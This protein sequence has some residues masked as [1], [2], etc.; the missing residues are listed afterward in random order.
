MNEHFLLLKSEF[1]PP[2]TTT[3]A[4]GMVEGWEGVG[5]GEQRVR[6][7]RPPLMT[8]WSAPHTHTPHPSR[9]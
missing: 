3:G 2:T 7:N 5:D 1:P 4:D 6:A 9:Q 8:G